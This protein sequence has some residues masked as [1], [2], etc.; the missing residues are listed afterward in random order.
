MKVLFNVIPEKGHLHPYIGVAQ[1]LQ[2]RGHEVAFAA[3]CDIRPQLARAGIETFL[4]GTDPP[5]PPSASRG[6]TFASTDAVVI[7]DEAHR[8]RSP[9]SR[10]YDMLA[11]GLHGARAL[12]VSAT[13]I[14]NRRADLCAQLALFAGRRVWAMTDDELASLVVRANGDVADERRL[15][16][17]NGPLPLT[18]ATDDD[19][20]DEI[21]LVAAQGRFE[22]RDV[23]R[24]G[25]R[26]V[27]EMGLLAEHFFHAV[28]GKSQE[29]LV[30]KNDRVTGKRRVGDRHRHAGCPNRVDE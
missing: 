20:L 2:R 5:P 1:A 15:P 23:V 16:E 10:R 24:I 22:P 18:L 6:A 13:P 28:A 25:V 12:L 26:A 19:C 9:A 21:V 17:L 8:F 11:S 29:R 30:G 7:V 27:H 4:G 3:A 14:H